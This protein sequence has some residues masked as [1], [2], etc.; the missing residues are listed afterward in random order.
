M[1]D[2]SHG[3]GEWMLSYRYLYMPMEQN[4]DGTSSI[5]DA[6]VM[7]PSGE[8][9]LVVPQWMGM[10]MHMFGIMHAPTDRLTMMLMLPYTVKEMGHLRRDGAEFVTRSSGWGDLKLSG[11]YQFES[12]SWAHSCQGHSLRRE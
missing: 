9:Y 11:I 8:S 3:K 5:S 1:G 12:W 6:D 7:S 10:K 2:H 4:Y